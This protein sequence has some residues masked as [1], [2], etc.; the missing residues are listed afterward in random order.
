MQSNLPLH[1]AMAAKKYGLSLHSQVLEES[2]LFLT[3]LEKWSGKMNLTGFKERDQII[4]K[5]FM[6]SFLLADK[7]PA[8]EKIIVDIGSG[9]GFPGIIIKLVHRDAL[10]VLIEA[11]LKKAV[12]LQEVRDTLGL[13]RIKIKRTRFENF[14]KD[15]EAYADVITCRGAWNDETMPALCSRLARSKGLLFR[16]IHLKDTETSLLET[17]ALWKIDKIFPLPDQSTA[18]CSWKKVFHVEHSP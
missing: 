18:I 1:F 7:I 15:R 14:C 10:V 8:G 4:H 2:A 6:E 13:R 17:P 16:F 3:L 12:F 11:N 5:L 9:A